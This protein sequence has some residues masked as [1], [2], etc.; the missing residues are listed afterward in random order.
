MGSEMEVQLMDGEIVSHLQL[1]DIR[2]VRV[3]EGERGVVM[4]G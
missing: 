2:E 4:R 1:S 3:E